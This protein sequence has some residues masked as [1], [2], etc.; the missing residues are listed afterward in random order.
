MS[1]SFLP[2]Y[3]QNWIDAECNSPEKDDLFDFQET[4][5]EKGDWV[6]I[7][8]GK[9]T[10]EENKNELDDLI[11]QY[12]I[13]KNHIPENETENKNK[14]SKTDDSAEKPRKYSDDMKNVTN[15]ARKKAKRRIYEPNK[16]RST[17]VLRAARRYSPMIGGM[18]QHFPKIALERIEEDVRTAK[19][20]LL[21]SRTN[22]QCP[23]KSEG[24]LVE[25][26]IVPYYGN[27]QQ[28]ISSSEILEVFHQLAKITCT[29]AIHCDSSQLN[30]FPVVQE[31]SLKCTSP[32][33]PIY[34]GVNAY[35]LDNLFTTTKPMK[36]LQ[37]M[38]PVQLYGGNNSTM[39]STNVPCNYGSFLKNVCDDII[40]QDY[41]ESPS[42]MFSINPFESLHARLFSTKTKFE[43]LLRSIM[44]LH[45][46]LNKKLESWKSFSSGMF[47]NF[48]FANQTSMFRSTVASTIVPQFDIKPASFVTT[49]EKSR[50]SANS[51]NLTT[52]QLRRQNRRGNRSCATTSNRQRGM[53]HGRFQNNVGRR[54]SWRC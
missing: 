50:C 8:Y 54:E 11:S 16:L 26:R 45:F 23:I 49:S 29:T 47:R 1:L 27:K 33:T 48:S 21:S 14:I 13:V 32:A 42:K 22:C 36:H 53:K 28:A 15:G 25:N 46:I 5:E 12:V 9:T 3:L 31:F 44:V 43:N 6:V 37:L 35:N 2:S 19:G 40:L 7:N 39:M 51:L 34:Q 30:R 41:R 4:T 20:M 52:K 38:S 24:C 18:P 10:N 17:E